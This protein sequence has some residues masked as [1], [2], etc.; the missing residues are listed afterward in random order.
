MGLYKRRAMLF[1][2]VFP[3]ITGV[4]FTILAIV[5]VLYRPTA[6]IWPIYMI[7]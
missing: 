4:F 1:V 3:D 7:V 5:S 2:Y 6:A